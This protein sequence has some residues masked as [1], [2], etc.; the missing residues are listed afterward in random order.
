M[1][2]DVKKWRQ[3]ALREG[4]RIT[5][6]GPHEKWYSPDGESIVTVGGTKISPVTL[7]NRRADLRRAGLAV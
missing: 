5:K 1:N 3:R 6:S 2:T 7:R 4:W